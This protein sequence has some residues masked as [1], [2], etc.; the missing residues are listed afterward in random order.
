MTGE[1]PS[2]LEPVHAIRYSSRSS[3]RL[4]LVGGMGVWLFLHLLAR[5]RWSPAL[6][7]TSLASDL[8]A[9]LGGVGFCFL[10]L[11]LTLSF[12]K[13]GKARRLA[14]RGVC[15][16][17]IPLAAALGEVWL[18]CR[19]TYA[20]WPEKNGQPYVSPYR[21]Q[22]STPWLH[23]FPP[24]ATVS[25]G[26][27]E[28]DYPVKTNS[29][30]LRDQEQPLEKG[31]GEYRIVALGD[32]FTMGQ[33]AARE[34]SYPRILGRELNKRAVSGTFRVMNAGVAGSDPVFA[35]QLLRR[36]LLRY[37]PD[38]VLL[39]VNYSDVTDIALRGGAER[40]DATGHLKPKAG[41]WF[42]PL[43]STSHL[44]RAWLIQFGDYDMYLMSSSQREEARRRS[45]ETIA[46]VARSL[47]NLGMSEGFKVLVVWHPFRHHL[48]D[49]SAPDELHGLESLLTAAGVPALDLIPVFRAQL[50]ASETD[51]YFWPRDGH[52]TPEGYACLATAIASRL[53]DLVEGFPELRL[54]SVDADGGG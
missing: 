48:T 14:F 38:L 5:T 25:L 29:E 47:L 12:L 53:P 4:L 22:S 23:L 20:S 18:R 6:H 19:G 35:E 51:R 54:P 32:S 9:F 30:G 3:E 44:V 27:V 17:A 45:T 43:F 34:E 24:N 26:T 16:I 10:S 37:H 8:G 13:P 31:P 52:C 21:Q 33:G 11:G 49:R 36:R 50:E 46:Q 15:L 2:E 39:L 7:L 1:G 28:F 41:P 42:E 40:F